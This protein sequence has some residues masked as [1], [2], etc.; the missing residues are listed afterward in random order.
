M[1]LK[2]ERSLIL[3]STHIYN[4]RRSK[5]RRKISITDVG[6]II[7]SG[8]K[9]KEFVLHVPKEYDYRYVCE[10]RDEFVNIL[11]L[12]FAN[13]DSENTL[14]IFSVS[15]N[16]GMYTTT[17]KD[18][19][20]GLYKLPEESQRKREEEIAGSRQMEEDEELE[21][22]IEEA[23]KELE[24]TQIAGDDDEV[25]TESE[26]VDIDTRRDSYKEELKVD[27]VND[28]DEDFDVEELREKSSSLL[29]SSLK[30]ES[31]VTLDDFEIISIL[32]KG[33][34]GKVYLTKMKET[35]KLYAIKTI[36]KDVVIETD[37]I[38]AVNLERDILFN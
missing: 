15:D 19:K 27:L 4:F 16:L 32:G 33:A 1:G 8:K 25:Y 6:A 35:G 21:K 23:Q 38:E 14:K 10:F 34:F 37:Q 36:R 5:V 28:D 9:E 13:L 2:Q 29:F 31:T 30:E 7:L 3:T 12:R 24:S 18:K 11:K 22:K 26:N 20:Y 17:L